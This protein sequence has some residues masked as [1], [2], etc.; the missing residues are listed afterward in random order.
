MNN[1]NPLEWFLDIQTLAKSGKELTSVADDAQR[2]KLATQLDVASVQSCQVDWIIKPWRKSDVR[3][4]GTLKAALTQTCSV[5]LE[6]IEAQI[7]EEID[8]RLTRDER[9]IEGADAEQKEIDIDP[10]G[11]DPPDLFDGR[12]VELGEIAF[13]HLALG[14][15]PYPRSSDVE[16]DAFQTD[17]SDQQTSDI[18][19]DKEVSPFSALAQLVD[20]SPTSQKN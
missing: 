17:K 4:I 20:T 3:V 2:Q 12:R 15:D 16:Y 8:V 18:G 9:L 1:T 6:P 5:S 7:L 11:R 13:E 19:G 10:E 14:L